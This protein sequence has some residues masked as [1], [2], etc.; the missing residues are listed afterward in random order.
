[1]ELWLIMEDS[2]LPN[3]NELKERILKEAH[4]TKYLIHPGNTKMHRNLKEVYCWIKMKRDTT[5]HV[6]PCN[7]CQK[8]WAEHQWP[9]VVA[10]IGNTLMEMGENLYGLHNRLTKNTKKTWCNLG[11]CRQIDKVRSLLTFE[12]QDH[13]GRTAQ[14]YMKNVVKLHRIPSSSLDRDSKFTSGFWKGLQKA[15]GAKLNFGI[16]FHP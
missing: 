1:M 9:G 14:L 16:A 11:G 4:C 5:S 3:I 2:A 8:V 12:I 13:L 10:T 7:V 15:M 6:V